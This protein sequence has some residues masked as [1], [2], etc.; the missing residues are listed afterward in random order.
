MTDTSVAW[1]CHIRSSSYYDPG[2][3]LAHPVFD[4]SGLSFSWRHPSEVTRVI[5]RV[6]VALFVSEKKLTPP[7][8]S[9]PVAKEKDSNNG[10][11]IYI[12]HPEDEDGQSLSICKQGHV[13]M[14]EGHVRT[15]GEKVAIDLSE[16]KDFM[17]CA[18]EGYVFVC[19][20]LNIPWAYSC[21]SGATDKGQCFLATLTTPFFA[22]S[23]KFTQLLQATNTDPFFYDGA[24]DRNGY[25][26]GFTLTDWGDLAFS[27]ERLVNLSKT[28]LT[29]ANETAYSMPHIKTYIATQLNIV[30]NNRL[31]QD[32]SL[33]ER[34]GFCKY[35][36]FVCCIS[37]SSL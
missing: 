37:V 1:I 36:K 16:K 4:P 9:F 15:W 6:R 23:E 10:A 20:Y 21:L 13:V 35:W 8:F 22:V 24:D 5:Y 28:L 31:A 14:L 11:D 34:A 30:L 3:P 33:V 26:F 27:Q 19:G 32:F 25:F 17:Y 2:D 29:I 12:M 7:C 18:P